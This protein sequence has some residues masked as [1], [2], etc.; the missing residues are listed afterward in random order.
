MEVPEYG[1][2]ALGAGGQRHRTRR[3]CGRGATSPSSWRPLGDAT[4]LEKVGKVRGAS[5]VFYLCLLLDM[6]RERLGWAI[7]WPQRHRSLMAARWRTG[8][9]HGT[10]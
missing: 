7:G 3:P 4:A 5:V 1:T 10:R 9:Q 2:V 6:E 8:P